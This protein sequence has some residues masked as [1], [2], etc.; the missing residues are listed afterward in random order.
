ML[1][2]AGN[3]I[4]G[5]STRPFRTACLA[6]AAGLLGVAS[7]A[8]G[9][10][11][12]D[13]PT[14]TAR[15]I[16]AALDTIFDGPHEGHR[17]AHAKGL[18]V[19]GSF[20][21]S[22]GAAL[23]TRAEHMSGGALP[24]IVRF[25]NFAGVPTVPDGDAAAT[26]NGMAIKFLLPEAGSTDIVAHSFD[27]FPA[28]TPTEFRAFLE[29][30]GSKDEGLLEQHLAAHPAARR[31][32]DTPKPVP[33]SYARQ[34]FFGVNAFQFTNEAGESRFG[35]YIVLPEAGAAFLSAEA[36][37]G[38]APDFLSTELLG[39]LAGS[40]VRFRLAVQLAAEG[41]SLT[42]GSHPW[43][44]SREIKE[45][46]TLILGSAA[47]AARERDILFTPL[48]LVDGILP[49][50]DPMLVSR[51]R[52]YRMSHDRRSPRDAEGAG[53]KGAGR[54]TAP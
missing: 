41:D 22:P 20:V 37:A 12:A 52:A 54:G 23:L 31:F 53:S 33:T 24:V 14:A 11:N 17:A 19:E 51:T 26:P 42:D 2:S 46:G 39:R 38:Q 5:R 34:R 8:G 49:S 21:P 35:R 1:A 43:P 13:S 6:L 50:D 40:P 44:D 7:A 32:V 18:L 9:E 45:L 25:S 36:A 47:D 16:I 48:N 15:G 29:A 4:D 10:P 30:L 3:R 27:G 28:A